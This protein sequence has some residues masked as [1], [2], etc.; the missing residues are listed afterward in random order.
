MNQKA[1]ISAEKC[2]RSPG[3][4]AMRFCPQKA[5]YQTEAPGRGWFGKKLSTVD[6]EK[7]TGCGICLRYCPR[8][9][10]QL[11]EAVA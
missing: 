9:A 2:D 10:I 5:I 4:P 8:K 3:C 6:T 7:C 11:Q 1:S